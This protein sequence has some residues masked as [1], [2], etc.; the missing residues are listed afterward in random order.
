MRTEA[1]D[2]LGVLATDEEIHNIIDNRIDLKKDINETIELFHNNIIK[3]DFENG[4][5]FEAYYHYLNNKEI[6]NSNY[7]EILNSCFKN[8]VKIKYI[9]SNNQN[10]GYIK[11]KELANYFLYRLFIYILL[12]ILSIHKLFIFK[13]I[14]LLIFII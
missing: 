3:T 10:I 4:K 12:G 1:I 2:W 5:Y 7:D 14:V 13:F 6:F 11:I 9:M 8:N